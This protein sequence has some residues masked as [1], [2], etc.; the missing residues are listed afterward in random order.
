[1]G[2]TGLAGIIETAGFGKLGLVLVTPVLLGEIV[3]IEI[4]E[5]TGIVCFVTLVCAGA[6]NKR[7][8]GDFFRLMITAVVEV[9]HSGHFLLYS[10]R[11]RPHF[12]QNGIV[13]T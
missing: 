5:L 12:R 6:L 8:E 2:T 10:Q 7:F 13:S 4:T 11:R 1:M 9:P 3:L